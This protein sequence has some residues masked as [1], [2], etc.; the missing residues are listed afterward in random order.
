MS[1]SQ[2]IRRPSRAIVAA[3]AILAAVSV[4]M[5]PPAEAHGG[6]GPGA[7]VGLGLG[8]FALGTAAGA[9]ANPYRYYG[10]A[11]PAYYYGPGYYRYGY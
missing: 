1:C 2:F 4:G 9:A 5:T 11:P 8:A 6:I 10:Y 7:A 3:A